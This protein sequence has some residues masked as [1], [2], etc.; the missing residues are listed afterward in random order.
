MTANADPGNVAVPRARSAGRACLF[1]LLRIGIAAALIAAL[2]PTF[3]NPEFF[4]ALRSVSL[5]LLALALFLSV[6]S[7]ASKAWRWGIV[8]RWRGIRVRNQY[9]L[10]SYFIS[11]FFNNFLPSGMGGDAVR[12]Y[13]SARDTGRATESVTAVILERGSGMLSLFAAGSLSLLLYP[14]HEL[15]LSITLLVHGL[16]LG[17]L[18]GTILLWQ[19]FTG[20]LLA[21]FGARLPARLHGLW[22]KGTA[23]YEDF[24][25][26]RTQ[27][28]LL[29]D[30]ML[31]SVVTLVLTVASLYTLIAA[32]GQTVPIAPFAAVIAI[33]T[34]IDLVPISPNGLGVREGVYV[35][36]LGRL[37][38][39]SGTA[40][41]FGILIRLL[42]LI[43]ALMGGL[44][45]LYRG[46]RPAR[47]MTPEAQ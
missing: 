40:L 16:F 27:Y 6:A 21:W 4:A 10:L 39:A 44:A 23:V 43:Q 35:F 36:L 30:L 24:K 37:G 20:A 7:V 32:L 46:A 26:Y 13:E 17:A 3:L 29:A 33:A 9:L 22:A 25:G 38:I 34:A 11:M 1:R 31:Q 14:G 47:P 18:I 5:P 2:L 19:D 41:A 42:V 45:F 15:P 28:R 12:A 8:L